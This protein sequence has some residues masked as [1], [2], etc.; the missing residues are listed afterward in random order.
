M[1]TQLKTPS[2]KDQ[3]SAEEWGLRVDLAAA[4]RLVAHYGWDDL[5]FTHL[6][7]RTKDLFVPNTHS[8]MEKV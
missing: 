8:H 3:V 2:V 6:S 5:I 7:V 4:Y 1:A